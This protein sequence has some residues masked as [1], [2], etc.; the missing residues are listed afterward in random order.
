MRTLFDDGW[1][2]ATTGSDAAPTP[3][4][5]P[6]DAMIHE[7]RDATLPGGRHT[8]WYPGGAYTYS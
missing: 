8:G 5:L 1:H 7:R 3:V 4:S 6:H 2:Y